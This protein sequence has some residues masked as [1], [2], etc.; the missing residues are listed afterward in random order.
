[1]DQSNWDINLAMTWSKKLNKL[2]NLSMQIIVDGSQLRLD[3][4]DIQ[5]YLNKVTSLPLQVVS[6][7]QVLLMLVL[8]YYLKCN[9][10]NSFL[11]Q[12]FT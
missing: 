6:F 7:L 5:N 10:V 3:P 12:S 9:E 1:M 2:D 4:K 8:W 11:Y